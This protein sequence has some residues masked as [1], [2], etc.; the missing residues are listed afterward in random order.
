MRD[1]PEIVEAVNRL[2]GGEHALLATVARTEGS[3]F[4]GRGSA[5]LFH[6]DGRRV[7][8][9]SG[10]CI[11][12]QIE[13][14]G[15]QLTETGPARMTLSLLSDNEAILG[16]GTGCRGV[17]EIELRRVRAGDLGPVPKRQKRLLICGGGDL[18]VPLVRM[19]GLAGWEVIVA[20]R[21][22]TVA[23]TARFTE[24][25]LIIA[26][27][28][29]DLQSRVAIDA[30][31]FAV[32]LTH[33]WLDDLEL[34]SLLLPSPA[35]YV[36]L[37]G[38]RDRTARLLAEVQKHG[39]TLTASHREKLHAPVGLDIG[40]ETA[41]EVAVSILAEL[42]AVLAGRAGGFLRNACGSI[43]DRA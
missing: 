3:T 32:L 13:E 22:P 12:R 33:D 16:Y 39:L 14:S 9:L 7:G 35:G 40:A 2:T 37:L 28:W 38:S 11:E 43:H 41:Q 17:I 4:R 15:W 31:T 5:M 27:P 19:A 23:T 30:Q 26:S 21:R 25:A 24:A 20:D 34:L 1:W 29:R 8:L 42:Q 6:R 36:G 18:S 10:G